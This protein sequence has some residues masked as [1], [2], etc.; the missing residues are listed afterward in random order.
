MNTNHFINKVY[1]AFSHASIDGLHR[2]AQEILNTRLLGE[3]I[4]NPVTGER[5]LT[6]EYITPAIARTLQVKLT[7][8]EVRQYLL[9]QPSYALDVRPKRRTEFRW[10]TVSNRHI[11]WQMD[12]VDMRKFKLGDNIQYLLTIIDTFSKYAFAIPIKSKHTRIVANQLDKLFSSTY[13]DA[14][15]KPLKPK[16]LLSDRGKEFAS[17]DVNFVTKYHNVLQIFSFPYTPLGI[18]ERFNQTIKRKIRKAIQKRQFVFDGDNELVIQG[19]VND[20]NQTIHSTIR[21]RPM[22][23]HFATDPYYTPKLIVSVRERFRKVREKAQKHVQTFQPGD[24]VRVLV[25]KDPRKTPFQQQTIKKQFT[26]KKFAKSY[27]TK[28]HFI[29]YEKKGINYT[30]RGHPNHLLHSTVLQK[31]V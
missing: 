17:Q 10:T 9:S 28:Q 5:H 31:V 29:I 16:L 26:Y 7:R 1:M 4:L 19:L 14:T 13:A 2:K 15:I 30:L 18:I 22:V 11:K 23:V 25:W 20:Y 24:I 21:Q 12:L 8:E 6:F 3:S 27:W